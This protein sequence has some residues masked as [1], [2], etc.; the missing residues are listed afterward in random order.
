MSAA[1]DEISQDKGALPMDAFAERLAF[2]GSLLP[3]LAAAHAYSRSFAE[4]AAV[5]S[6]SLRVA[7]RY[8]ALAGDVAAALDGLDRA[9]ALPDDGGE[10]LF[11]KGLLLLGQ[12]DS[13]AALTAFHGA[14][15]TAFG[16]CDAEQK[17]ETI[18][19]A[20]A[21]AN[22]F[23][24]FEVFYSNFSSD[25]C[26]AVACLPITP[27]EV[28]GYAFCL[29]RLCASGI[30]PR[31]AI[32][33]I[34]NRDETLNGASYWSQ[35]NAGHQFWL[36]G[37]RHQADIAYAHARLLAKLTGLTPY[38]FNC[39]VLVWLPVSKARKLA[40]GSLDGALSG[41]APVS[42]A[43]PDVAREWPDHVVS[44]HCD[45]ENFAHFPRFLASLC[46]AHAAFGGAAACVLHCHLA[47]PSD[48]LIRML[49][50]IAARIAH[51]YPKLRLAFSH[52]VP[53]F[54]E[55]GYA[56]CLR[57]LT[58]AAL[59]E[60]YD[61]GVLVLDIEC[62]VEE[63]LFE[64]LPNVSSHQF[65]M[66][67]HTFDE[68]DQQI[69]G[70]PWSITSYPIYISN[71]PIG[72]R[73][74]DFAVRYIHSAYDPSLAT[75]WTIDLVV[76]AQAHSLIVQ[77]T[78]A[79]VLNLARSAKLVRF[80][81]ELGDIGRLAPADIPTALDA[82][83]H[84][85]VE[86]ETAPN[87]ARLVEKS[88]EARR[89]FQEN[90]E[91]NFTNSIL[92]GEDLTR[93][94]FYRE[95]FQFF[96]HA[97]RINPNSSDALFAA[98][99]A[100]INA[101]LQNDPTDLAA[102]EGLDQLRFRYLSALALSKSGSS[103]PEQILDLM[104]NGFEAMLNGAMDWL[105]LQLAV[106]A[107]SYDPLCAPRDSSQDRIPKRII[108]YWDHNPP[109]EIL[110]NIQYHRSFESAEILFFDKKDAIDFLEQN[111]GPDTV[112]LF[113]ELRHPA[114]ESDFFRYHAINTLGG[115]YLDTDEQL[116]SPDVLFQLGEAL[117]GV[118]IHSYSGPLENC[119]FGSV[120]NSEILWECLQIM[121]Y[122]HLFR[123]KLSIWLKTGPGVLTRAITRILYRRRTHGAVGENFAIYEKET[124]NKIRRR[125]DVSYRGDSRDWSFFESQ[126]PQSFQ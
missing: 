123:P 21:S 118:Y 43:F 47:D 58:L 48:E 41:A 29:D 13:A 104:G 49:Q 7:A 27:A 90:P 23:S 26:F 107:R 113:H 70:E 45:P 65:G 99:S 56:T 106:P 77:G 73:F 55:R 124:T 16:A 69:R 79:T 44:V 112:K 91:M 97:Y 52:G 20:L 35:V 15:Q 122:H 82:I 96:Y 60:H 33:A 62:L 6:H 93:A 108:F 111:Y 18:A 105:Y 14:A 68:N 36:D 117:G 100:Q 103:S 67:K 120:A 116:I 10:A 57:F 59:L 31:P 126:N 84:V 53:A 24:V 75:N 114:E 38:H 119:I 76:L 11:A 5:A 1:Q 51:T 32:R 50:E 46:R 78:R 121:V 30:W 87:F 34:L 89:R 125:V 71:S 3:D 37:D 81:F 54:H 12:G 39:G 22:R 85:A 28:Q 61:A 102:L 8:A 101:G 42:W 63:E 95:A 92:L 110:Q 9:A 115:Y 74:T 17:A 2:F 98:L 83:F 86:M 72:Q 25:F 94:A 66:W 109:E 40:E 64:L 80:P 4:G 19:R 88:D